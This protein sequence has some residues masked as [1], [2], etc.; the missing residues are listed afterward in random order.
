[1]RKVP[2]DVRIVNL[3]QVYVCYCVIIVKPFFKV[4]LI[5]IPFHVLEIIGWMPSWYLE[6][7]RESSCFSIVLK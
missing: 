4:Q 5:Y 7:Q 3:T 1:M 6:S 2:F